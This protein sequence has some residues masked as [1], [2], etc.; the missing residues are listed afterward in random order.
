MSIISKTMEKIEIIQGNSNNISDKKRNDIEEIKENNENISELQNTINKINLENKKLRIEKELLVNLLSKK[1]ES[2]EYEINLFISFIRKVFE[3]VDIL[4]PE[5][6][7][8]VYG[9]FLE[10][11]I[12][13]KPI[14][15]EKVYFLLPYIQ[16]KIMRQL[17]NCIYLSY[18]RT[19][20]S[21][22]VKQQ[23][24]YKT[25]SFNHN[26]DDISVI[27]YYEFNLMLSSKLSF[28]VIIHD[29]TY[30]EDVLF[31]CD[32]L[33]MD[34]YGIHT[35]K[36]TSKDNYNSNFKYPSLSLLKIIDNFGR[37]Q[38]ELSIHVSELNY[39]NHIETLSI[40]NKQSEKIKDGKNILGGFKISNKKDVSCSI[41]YRE[42]LEED[43]ILYE[44][45]C[46]HVFCFDC[47]DKHMNSINLSHHLDC[48]LC[49]QNIDFIPNLN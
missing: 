17:I 4:C 30:L 46:N 32:N 23:I 14:G 34:K 2:N 1:V 33:V 49:R 6:N 20:S 18:N 40:L 15:K 5:I 48:P 28:N 16:Q 36:I 8:Y 29:G 7:T 25:P 45:V 26:D 3:Y 37:N 10:N 13:L 35:K 21:N 11:I 39:T 12:T 43:A 31:D 42:H 44:L 47:I 24:Y 19:G 22:E 38:A 27:N 41:C 9:K